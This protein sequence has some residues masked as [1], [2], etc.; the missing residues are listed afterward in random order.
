MLAVQKAT[1]AQL[2][3]SLHERGFPSTYRPPDPPLNPL[4]MVWTGILH[5]FPLSSHQSRATSAIFWA[6]LCVSCAGVNSMTD[7][8]RKMLL[9]EM[10]WALQGIATDSVGGR[11]KMLLD[12]AREAHVDIDSLSWSLLKKYVKL[13]LDL[14]LTLCNYKTRI[15]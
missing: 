7:P 14:H 11:R 4:S 3:E 8:A 13:F 6:H 1:L 10:T 15:A 12:S 9:Q 2:G 5:M